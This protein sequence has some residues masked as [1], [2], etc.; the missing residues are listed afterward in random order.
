MYLDAILDS[1]HDLPRRVI[2]DHLM[3]VAETVSSEQ[4]FAAL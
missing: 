1:S 4:D 2:V 3:E